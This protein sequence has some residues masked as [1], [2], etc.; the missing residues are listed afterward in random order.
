MVYIL[1]TLIELG[2]HLLRSP[3][4]LRIPAYRVIVLAAVAC[5]VVVAVL[6]YITNKRRN[7]PYVNQSVPLLN[8]KDS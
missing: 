5:L 8:N 2:V 3:N 4:K 1:C 6:I 7:P